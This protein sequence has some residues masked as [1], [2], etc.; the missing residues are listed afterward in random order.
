MQNIEKPAIQLDIFDLWR[1]VKKDADAQERINSGAVDKISPALATLNET[2]R[3]PHVNAL[4]KKLRYYTRHDT[5]KHTITARPLRIFIGFPDAH[6]A[7]EEAYGNI[8]DETRKR[9]GLLHTLS[10]NSASIADDS[11]QIK[12][13]RW[14]LMDESEGGLRVRTQVS[15]FTTKISVGQVVAFN[16]IH[17]K[18]QELKLGFISR[19]NRLNE[20]EIDISVVKL[21]ESVKS[22]II[23][24]SLRTKKEAAMIGFLIKL[25]ERSSQIVL[26][27]SWK[28]KPQQQ[29]KIHSYEGQQKIVVKS[30]SLQQRNFAIYDIITIS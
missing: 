16:D 1:I 20:A 26:P 3:T 8:D 30:P 23:Q 2:D 25:N 29:L 5:R 21:G 14:F 27:V 13:E 7:L 19:I 22:I 11:Q 6:K 10:E 17:S 24:D 28:V 12:D 4:I 15:R 9:T 18:L